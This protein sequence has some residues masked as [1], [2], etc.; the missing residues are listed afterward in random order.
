MVAGQIIVFSILIFALILFIWGKWRYDVV[1]FFSLIAAVIAGVIPYNEAFSGFNNPAVITVAEVMIISAAIASS[2]VVAYLVKQITRITYNQFLHILILTL[3]AAL[4]SA[5]MN[6][7]GA[8]GLLMPI[9]METS[10]KHNRS[11]ALI[12]M[13]LAFASILGGLI[14]LIGTPPNILIASVRAETLGKPFSMFDF[15]PVGLSLTVVGLVFIVLIGWR[16][17]PKE[18]LNNKAADDAFHIQDYI[19]EIQIPSDSNILNKTLIEFES[20]AGGKIIV[21][22]IIRDGRKRLR[23]KYDDILQENDILI[24]E[25]STDDLEKLLQTN[26]IDLVGSKSVSFDLLSSENIGVIEVVVPPTSRLEGRSAQRLRLRSKFNINLLA[27]ARQGHAFNRRLLNVGLRAGDVLLLQG[28]ADNLVE[29]VSEIGFLPLAE[30]GL[31]IGLPRTA[32]FPL[33]IFIIALFFAAKGIVPITIAFAVVIIVLLVFNIISP[34]KIYESIDFSVLVLLGAMIPIGNAL[35]SSGGTE[36][37][38]SGLVHLSQHMPHWFILSLVLVITMTLSD[39]MNNAATA[40]VMA[41]IAVSIAQTLHYNIDP[42]LMI[43]AVGASC[44]FL[45]PIG[46]QNNTLV[47]GPG[48]YH[49][50]DY[51]RMGLPLEIIILFFSVPLVMWIWP[52]H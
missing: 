28:K 32:F 4:L 30:R 24:I 35:Q 38:A 25:A 14:T 17:I 1:A 52:L 16:L 23:L 11:P 48:G 51:W 33:V 49:F 36:L 42:F 45:T 46:H 21:L 2:G 27:L 31:K 5:F 7:V 19:T 26:K 18:R 44:A 43:V 8:L 20:I 13:P 9:A 6:N 29:T 22:G 41:P 37:I 47:M 12:L 50:G 10:R 39:V 3:I 34:R 40:V 15:T